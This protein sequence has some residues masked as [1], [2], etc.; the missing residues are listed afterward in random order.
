MSM[1]GAPGT[2][3]TATPTDGSAA[4][5]MVPQMPPKLCP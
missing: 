3:S 5:S 1:I 2:F 4:A